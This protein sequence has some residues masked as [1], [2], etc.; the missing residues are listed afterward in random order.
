MGTKKKEVAVVDETTKEVVTAGV[1]DYG[2]D[3]GAGFEGITSAD[4]AIPFLNLLQANSP[5][6]ESGEHKSGQI[7]NSVNG[8]VYDG[9]VGVPFQAVHHEHKFVKWKPR[10][11]G[12]G[13]IATYEATDPYIEKVKAINEKTYGKLKTEDGNDL[14]ETHYIY[15]HV[16]NDAGTEIEGFALLAITGTKITPYR[17]WTTAMFEIKGKP[18]LF[19][20]RC[21]LLTT[22]E[23]ND[24]GQAYKNIEFKPLLEK[25][26]VKSLIPPGDP[27]LDKAK[28]LIS[29]V[30]S[31]KAKA[32]FSQQD[33]SGEGAAAPTPGK[34]S[35]DGPVPF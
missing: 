25:N 20:F 9:D 12:G 1:Y 6:V 24:K 10:E 34:A 23:K 35:P 33:T 11:S 2:A 13:I 3:A 8:N 30:Q 21:R 17:K 19:A 7:V 15:G 31:G 5:T 16:L 14:I 29:M 18:P 32:D 27:L 22:S 28:D 26:W 4:L